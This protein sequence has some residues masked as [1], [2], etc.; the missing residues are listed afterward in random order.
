M[1]SRIYGAS[2]RR[3]KLT[4]L[5]YQPRR[6]DPGSSASAYVP[7]RSP[8]AHVH[9]PYDGSMHAML[10]PEGVRELLAKRWGEMHPLALSGHIPS[11]AVMLF[12]PRDDTDLEIILSLLSLSYD[13]ARGQYGARES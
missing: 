5:R 1:K 11:T 10:P 6:F 4:C 3:S 8:L 2:V 9:P 12:G 13:F 7:S